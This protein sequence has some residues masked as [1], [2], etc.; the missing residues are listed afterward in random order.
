MLVNMRKVVKIGLKMKSFALV[1]GKA[2][3]LT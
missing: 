3:I 1:V 2:A